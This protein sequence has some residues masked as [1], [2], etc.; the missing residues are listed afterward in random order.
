MTFEAFFEKKRIDLNKL[1]HA[2]PALYQEF[3]D[4]FR[5]MGERS[6]D[7]TKKFWFNKLRK[8]FHLP[9]AAVSPKA[10]AIS[11]SSVDENKA[12]AEKETPQAAAPA[13]AKPAGFK[14]RFKAPVKKAAEAKLDAPEVDA[15]KPS[16]TAS[17][18]AGFKPRFKAGVTKKTTDDQ[19][20]EKIVNPVGSEVNNREVEAGQLKEEAADKKEE[21]SGS[22]E[23]S[24]ATKS[25]KPAGFKP[26]FKAGLTTKAAPKTEAENISDPNVPEEKKEEIKP[27]T[28]N[29]EPDSPAPKANKPT[30]FKPR[31]KAGVTKKPKDGDQ[32]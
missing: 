1:R 16:A 20:E 23:Q 28:E 22:E 8:R 15:A 18:P 10:A 25:N 4:H 24:V 14:P 3:N 30:G 19:A 21:N 5:L 7:H 2:E 13:A 6:F 9:E 27:E 29:T 11:N 32:Q 17:K 12:I 31:F 26:R